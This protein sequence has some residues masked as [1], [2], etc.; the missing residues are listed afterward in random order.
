MQISIPIPSHAQLHGGGF[1]AGFLHPVLGVDHLLAMVAVGIIST[2]IGGRAIYL[3]PLSFVS[4]M[5]I[6]SLFGFYGMQFLYNEVGIA[7]SLLLLGIFMS[8]RWKFSLFFGMSVVAFFA[9][10]HGHAH[11]VEIPN[12]SSVSHYISGF[13]VAT[14]LLHIAG[15]A[16]GL[17]GERLS[18]G[19]SFLSHV[20][21]AISGI[22]IYIL[23]TLA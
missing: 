3:V 9:F 5:F 4:V 14:I 10:F 23:Y 8:M 11:G 7:I 22:G 1:E 6:G 21:S 16:I 17:L 19:V 13:V 2:M 15:V 12:I 20:G 18:Q